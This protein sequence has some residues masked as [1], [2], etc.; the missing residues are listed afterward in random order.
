MLNVRFL[1]LAG[2]ILAAAAARLLPHPPNV[3]PIAAMALFG[4]AYFASKRSAF[5]VPLSAMLLGDI[6]LG[7][8]QYG[9]NVFLF[10]PYVY[11]G[12]AGTT[13]LGLLLR[14]RRTVMPIAAACLASSILFFLITN[15]GAWLQYDFYP[16]TPDGLLA[17]YVAALPFFHNTVIGDAVCTALLFGGFALAELYFPTL[18]QES[19][20]IVAEEIPVSAVNA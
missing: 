9:M 1:S 17:S 11:V 8:I 13:C 2:I 12:F 4:G 5:L 10:A 3:T 14:S 6:A 19:A 16:K 7:L 20:S 15:F 18:R